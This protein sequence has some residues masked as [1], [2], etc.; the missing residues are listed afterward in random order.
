VATLAATSPSRDLWHTSQLQS[1]SSHRSIAGATQQRDLASPVQT[2]A[3]GPA[4]RRVTGEPLAALHPHQ[5]GSL[6]E[7]AG[8]V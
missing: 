2:R 1:T 7:H 3:D 5:P 6:A 8:L 4:R